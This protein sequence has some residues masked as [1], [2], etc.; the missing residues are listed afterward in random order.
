M[1]TISQALEVPEETTEEKIKLQHFMSRVMFDDSLDQVSDILLEIM[2][3]THV[4][5]TPETRKMGARLWVF[6]TAMMHA[7]DDFKQWQNQPVNDT[8]V[9]YQ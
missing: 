3:I 1:T 2:K 4:E 6:M 9:S 7:R 5:D 8:A